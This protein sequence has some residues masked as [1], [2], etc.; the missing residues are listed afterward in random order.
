MVW[1]VRMDDLFN[2]MFGDDFLVYEWDKGLKEMIIS[3]DSFPCYDYDHAQWEE[4]FSTEAT[5][6][7][8]TQPQHQASSSPA[9]SPASSQ[10]SSPSASPAS[11]PSTSPATSPSASP[12]S[13]KSARIAS[14][15]TTTSA[16]PASSKSVGSASPAGCPASSPSTGSV[17]SP[18]TN[19][20]AILSYFEDL[21]VCA[22]K[23]PPEVKLPLSIFL[24][25]YKL[26]MMTSSLLLVQTALTVPCS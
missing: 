11:S 17:S 14:S 21:R 4:N 12:A 10:A 19:S 7:T 20:T 13:S 23:I 1:I 26:Q 22:A 2:K 8:S 15:V 24:P 25:Y 16:K 6:Y 18:S 5:S 3:P 9:F